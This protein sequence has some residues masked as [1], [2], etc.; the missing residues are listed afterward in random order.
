MLKAYCSK[1]KEITYCTVKCA[2]DVPDRPSVK[3]NEFDLNNTLQAFQGHLF[4]FFLKLCHGQPEVQLEQLRL[5]C[6]VLLHRHVLL[7][8]K[9]RHDQLLLTI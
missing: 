1:T 9:P 6:L 8:G 4:R 5:Q 2:Y 3:R 7:K